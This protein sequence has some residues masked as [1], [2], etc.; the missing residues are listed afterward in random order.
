MLGLNW[1]LANA[2]KVENNS[3]FPRICCFLVSREGWELF[4]HTA[5]APGSIWAGKAAK[6]APVA[7]ECAG[8]GAL[9]QHSHCATFVCLSPRG[10][11]LLH[12]DRAKPG[13]SGTAREQ[14]GPSMPA[15]LRVDVHGGPGHGPVSATAAVWQGRR[16]CNLAVLGFGTL[17]AGSWLQPGPLVRGL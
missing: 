13:P 6:A 16:E 5:A 17:R 1:R 12:V 3:F 7:T 15:V 14:F 9:P 4:G 8:V 2:N 11:W 10:F